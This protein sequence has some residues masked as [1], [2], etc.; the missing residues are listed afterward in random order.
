[1]LQTTDE[2]KL[3][4]YFAEAS[5]LR[6][7]FFDRKSEPCAILNA[8]CG[9]C[10]ETCAFCAQ[11]SRSKA[12]IKKYPLVSE[13]NIFN[14]ARQAAANGA[15]YF[16]IVTSGRAVEYGSEELETICRSVKKIASELPVKPCA[17]LGILEK[18]ALNKLK[19]TG[20]ERYHHNLEASGSY[21]SS[22]CSSRTFKDQLDAV[23]N[24]KEA[25]LAVCCGGIFG[26]GETKKQ[27]V[28]LLET[29]RSLDI[30]S[31]PLNFLTPIPGTPL[32][33]LNELTPFECLKTIAAARLMMPDKS[34]RICGGREYN[35]KDFQSWIFFAGADSMMI[36][37]YLVTS[38]R[39]VQKDIEMIKN[40]GMILS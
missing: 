22:I 36:G 38:G 35:L 24:A 19:D 6:K 28:E 12:D 21:F 14:S 17:S 18:D 2:T 31:V 29:V 7:K 23:R 20:L 34:I 8:R 33:S 9:N 37:N 3:Y 10:S 16:S 25:G 4:N 39:D 5:S 15:A 11:S 1:M 30:D 27:R 13:E 26:M 40:A 32:E